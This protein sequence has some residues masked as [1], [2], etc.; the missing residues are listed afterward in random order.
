MLGAKDAAE[1]I[2]LQI[3][4]DYVA[5]SLPAGNNICF[6]HFFTNFN[7]LPALK[8]YNARNVKYRFST[9]VLNFET[10]H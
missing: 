1:S 9:L 8:I 10:Q 6:Q 2:F 5:N 3:S 7:S 4:F